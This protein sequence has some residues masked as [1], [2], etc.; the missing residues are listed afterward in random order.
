ML[1][2][3]VASCMCMAVAHVA[4]K[5]RVR[6]GALYVEA[7]GEADLAAFRFAE[8]RL[9]VEAD[10][11]KEE[12]DPLVAFARRYCWVSNTLAAGCRVTTAAES[13]ASVE[14]DA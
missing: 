9:T 11:P 13:I 10:L 5:R 6:L 1:L 14:A 2:A 4:R 8:I 3:S 7:E 12:L